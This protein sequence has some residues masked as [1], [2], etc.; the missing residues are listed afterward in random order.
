MVL[1]MPR[2]AFAQAKHLTIQPP[3]PAEVN[4]SDMPFMPLHDVR[5]VRSRAWLHAKNWRGEGPGL[6]FC[7]MNL[8][9]GA[10]RSIP[11]GS[12]EDD[13]DVLADTARVSIE[14]WKRM[15]RSALR[16][17]CRNE[18]RL[19]HPVISQVA[20]E[21]WIAR[22]ETRHV[23]T[24]DSHRAAA[25]RAMDKGLEPPDPPGGYLDWI[26]AN[27]P[28]TYRF[29]EEISGQNKE[30]GPKSLPDKPQNTSEGDPKRSK[31]K[32][33]TPLSPASR[34]T[35]LSFQNG[36]RRNK[37]D[38]RKW[39]ST[40]LARLENEFRPMLDIMLTNLQTPGVTG[41][42][43]LV[44]DFKGCWIQQGAD[45]NVAIV[46]R[47]KARAMAIIKNHG[48]WLFH[49]W[50]ELKVRHAQTEELRTRPLQ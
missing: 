48:S 15:K 1:Q 30:A 22:L 24:I 43:G 40:E 19:W 10:F 4:L 3:L 44:K 32:Q 31:G 25:K 7:L 45:Q 37:A 49:Y 50:P 29:R 41:M 9:M 34:P 21:L 39:F 8:W 42:F 18:G 6:A 12:L 20:W 26:A 16:G 46:A 17:W 13:D 28:A 27:Y 38:G 35:D 5:L 47:S 11:A 33:Y 23:R 14:H 2:N 36:P